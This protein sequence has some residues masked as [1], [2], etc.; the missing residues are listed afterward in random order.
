LKGL[1]EEQGELLSR[2]VKTKKGN[3]AG[4]IFPRVRILVSELKSGGR[5]LNRKFVKR[6]FFP[7]V[8]SKYLVS[9]GKAAREKCKILGLLERQRWGT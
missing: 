5:L 3:A 8:G 4:Q 9:E 2:L 1:S 7:P 6:A